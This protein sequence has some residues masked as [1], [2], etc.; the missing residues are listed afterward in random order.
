MIKIILLDVD[1]VLVHPGG[2]LAALDATVNYLTDPAFHIHEDMLFDMERRGISS[3]WDMSPLL[4]ASY[5][6]EILSRQPIPN[7]PSDVFSAALEIRRQRKVDIPRYLPIPGFSVIPGQYPAETAFQLGHFASI[8][9]NLRKNLLLETRNVRLSQTMRIFQHFAL[10]SQKFTETYD[11]PAELQTES[12]LLLYDR[13]NINGQIRAKLCQPDHYLVAFT[14]R[15][16]QPP[17]MVAGSLIGFAPEAE[18]ALEL[19][20]LPDIP[21]IAFGSLEFIASQYGLD[22]ATLVKPS[23]FH[24]LAA[25]LAAWTKEEWIALQAAHYWRETGELNGSFLQ[26]PKKFDL[27]V[28]EDTMGGIRSVRAAGEVLRQAGLDVNV[29]AIGLTD[30]S[31]A[32]ASAFEREG[33]QYFQDWE[34]L[35]RTIDF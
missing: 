17:E 28:M 18:L 26:L 33:V 30:G 29:R 10:G 2:Y 32:K 5:W 8:P 7:L 12:F 34:S 14:S 16:S 35:V 6:N 19:V 21:L 22:P 1:S 24:A 13:S 3:E 11:L 31:I 25:L 9:Y 4:I 27:I 20:S 23:P 15:P